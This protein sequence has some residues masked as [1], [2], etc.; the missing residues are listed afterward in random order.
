M[1]GAGRAVAD[2]PELYQQ[3]DS[4]SGRVFSKATMIDRPTAGRHRL[5]TGLAL[6]AVV[7]LGS[8]PVLACRCPQLSLDLYYERAELVLVGRVSSVR[9]AR[10]PEGVDYLA[11]EVAPV[12]NQ[13]RPFKGALDGRTLATSTSSASCG[14]EVEVGETYLIFASSSEGEDG[15]AWFDSCSGSRLYAGGPRAS[16][17]APFT[18]L[19]VQ[20]IVPRLF[21]LAGAAAEPPRDHRAVLERFHT[22]PACW[23]E[24]RIFHEGRPAEPLRRRV[25]LS[26]RRAS[27]PTEEPTL[28]PNGAYRL[29]VR[30]ADTSREGPWDAEVV[31]DVERPELLHMRL[32]DVSVYDVSARWV[33]EKLIFVRVPWGRVAFSDLIADVEHGV[34][35]HEEAA[36]DGRIAFQQY[37]GECA[38]Q[39]PCLAV[40]G[41]R[42][43]LDRPPISRPASG[44]PEVSELLLGRLTYLNDEWNG[45]VF[46]EAGGRTFTLS[47][48]KGVRARG[49]YP[50]NLLE[51]RSTDSGAWLRVEILGG[52]PCAD[53]PTAPVHKGWIPAYSERGL[54]VAG[55]HP[56]GC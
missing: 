3:V 14:V 49:E 16:E 10:T 46:S 43:E 39:C 2:D 1:G 50:V 6:I 48:I 53:T 26:W 36:R 7:G 19:E 12:F 25:E 15:P 24:P 31:V 40:P 29:W 34:L 8:S 28:S 22:S 18:G 33:N 17:V 20:R 32:A 55:Y 42:T 44:E 4:V 5:L 23:G 56:G 51:L 54:L 52:D 27:A 13:R 35:V 11:V 30:Q 21:E 38:G 37:Q 9:P 41:S 45:R 47:E